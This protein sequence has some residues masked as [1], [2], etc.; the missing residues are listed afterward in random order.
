MS[1]EYKLDEI[2]QRVDS[3]KTTKI[4]AQERLDN[5]LLQLR[6]NYGYKTIE[7]AQEAYNR[8]QKEIPLLETKLDKLLIQVED[9]LNAIEQ[10]MHQ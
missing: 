5:A 8:T 3:L 1:E 10:N 7:E 9:K 6:E 4:R 2:K